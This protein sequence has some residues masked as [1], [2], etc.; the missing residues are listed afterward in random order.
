MQGAGGEID[1]SPAK[2]ERLTDPQAGPGENAKR[3]TAD[4]TEAQAE[5]RLI[6]QATN[7]RNRNIRARKAREA[8]AKKAAAAKKKNKNGLIP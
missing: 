7:E 3:D 4:I 5:K 8:A 1:V 2:R 6:Q